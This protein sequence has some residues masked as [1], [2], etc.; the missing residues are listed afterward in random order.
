MIQCINPEIYLEHTSAGD[1]QSRP[2]NILDGTGLISTVSTAGSRPKLALPAISMA[3]GIRPGGGCQGRTPGGP[4]RARDSRSASSVV[5]DNLTT[6]IVVT[7]GVEI[8][9]TAWVCG[10]FFMGNSS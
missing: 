3:H 7:V 2:E 10:A 6:Q 5:P 9:L 1:G 4:N 8:L